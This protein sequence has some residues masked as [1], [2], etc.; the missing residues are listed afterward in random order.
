MV[1]PNKFLLAA[2]Y[3]MY[4]I[5]RVTK[6]TFPKITSMSRCIFALAQVMHHFL[7]LIMWV[8]LGIRGTIRPRRVHHYTRVLLTVYIVIPSSREHSRL[9]FVCSRL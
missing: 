2:P 7:L 9:Y 4:M 5:E 8:P 1:D 3:I 6:I